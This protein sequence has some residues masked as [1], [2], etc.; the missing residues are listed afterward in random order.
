MKLGSRGSAL[1]L[2]QATTVAAAI[3]GA[4]L[5]T[6]TTSG[7][8]GH[9]GSDDKERWVRELDEALLDRRIDLAVHSAKDLPAEL[10]A[11]LVIAAT[12]A[13]ASPFDA[14]C[15]AGAIDQLPSGARVGTSS[16]RRTA[17][18]RALRDDLQLV[19]LHGNVDTRL[20][21]LAGG[22]YDAIVIAFAGLQRLQRSEEAGAVLDQLIP[23]AGQ[24][25]LAITARAD[26]Q[27]SIAI[28][29]AL[30]D[31][32][33]HRCLDAER[34]LIQTLGADCQTPV[35][36]HAT[37]DGEAMTLAAFVGRIDGSVWL[38]D[39]LTVSGGRPDPQLL[40]R[41]VGERLLSAGANEVLGR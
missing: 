11:G 19:D 33:S 26:D 40:G 4:E 32:A 23:A 9:D 36:A 20:A 34:A 16:L 14:L 8:R 13:R 25:T 28:A 18:L 37:L 21:A 41:E 29:A 6:I 31:A 17:Q 38:R 3:D 2:A 30:D 5:Q 39:Q 22:D 24:G 10:A 7:D 27:Q 1:A 12:P 35:G 15:G